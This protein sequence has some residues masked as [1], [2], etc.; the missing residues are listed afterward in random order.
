MLVIVSAVV[1]AMIAWPTIGA[2]VTGFI[3]GPAG[4]SRTQ[5]DPVSALAMSPLYRV[6][7]LYGRF[8]ILYVIFELYLTVFDRTDQF[9]HVCGNTP[10]TTTGGGG[11]GVAVLRGASL[12][13]NGT[14]QVCTAHP[15]AYEWFLYALIRLPS[16]ILWGA[17]LLLLWQLIWRAARNGPF[18]QQSAAFMY[19]VGL[20]I[21]IGT[22]VAAAVSALGADLLD[23]VLMVHPGFVGTGIAG[24]VL[25]DSLKALVPWPAL[26]GA[27]LISFARI[28]LLGTVLS[29]EVR[30]TV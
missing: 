9:P 14:V 13:S 18:T 12:Q 4:Q 15:T 2:F 28:T 21:L 27:A 6:A 5:V 29:D 23:R 7:T 8:L 26:V 11:S 3:K 17:V 30:A 1:L 22:A 25:G 16:L 24:D 19:V 20:V 10:F